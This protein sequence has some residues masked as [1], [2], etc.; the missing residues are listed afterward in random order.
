MK[1]ENRLRKN[2]DF[3]RIINSKKSEVSKHLVVYYQPNTF[4]K[5]RVGISVSKKFANAVGRNRLRRQVRAILDDVNIFNR[6]LDV[7]V[8]MRKPFMTATYNEK[9]QSLNKILKRI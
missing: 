2:H 4:N 8:I 9:I 7:V 6:S 1:K 5:M 3:Q